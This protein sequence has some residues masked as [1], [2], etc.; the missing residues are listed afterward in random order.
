VGNA[1]PVIENFYTV[2]VHFADKLTVL[3]NKESVSF[4]SLFHH[5]RQRVEE[6]FYSV[7]STEE[8]IFNLSHSGRDQALFAEFI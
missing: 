1:H 2:R 4:F 5:T 8:E 7:N 3:P 6:F